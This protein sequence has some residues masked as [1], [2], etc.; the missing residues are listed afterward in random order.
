MSEAH[1]HA[2]HEDPTVFGFWVYI[3]SDCVIF[4]SLFAAY[5]VVHNN[6]ASA[7]SAREL[8]SLPF[9]LVETLILLSSSFTCGLAMVAAHRTRLYE[10]LLWSTA[11][12]ALGITFVSLEI[13]EFAKLIHEGN[14]PTMS[15]FLSSFFALVGTHGAHVAAGS[16]WLA[17]LMLQVLLWGFTHVTIRR[18][19]CWSLFWHFLD[20][21]WIFIFTIVYLMS[22]L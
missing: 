19:M 6:T 8:F 12:L 20:I 13:N 14:G 1:A 5:A 10:T 21:V 16:L 22:A 7:S 18:L 9:V 17:V 3:M 4:A 2:H 11:T 15:A